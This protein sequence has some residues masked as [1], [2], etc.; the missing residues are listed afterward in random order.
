MK[1]ETVGEKKAHE[2]RHPLTSLA[3]FTDQFGKEKAYL[4]LKLNL[5]KLCKQE[6]SPN[7]TGSVRE[8]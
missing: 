7:Y 1:K 2:L 5:A 8:I 3:A 6:A 4:N